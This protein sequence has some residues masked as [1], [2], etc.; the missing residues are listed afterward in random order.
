MNKED[1]LKSQIEQIMDEYDFDRVRD[2]M[3]QVGWTWGAGKDAEVPSG[4]EIRKC[5]RNCMVEAAKEG[6]MCCSTGG[7]FALKVT[8]ENTVRMFLFWGID[9]SYFELKDEDF[10]EEKK[11]EKRRTDKCR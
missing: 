8:Y 5:A 1:V 6:Q 7:F 9:S 11:N 2:I 10:K 3:K 4:N